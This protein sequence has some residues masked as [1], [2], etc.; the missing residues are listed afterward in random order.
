M[1]QNEIQPQGDLGEGFT[2][3]MSWSEALSLVQISPGSLRLQGPRKARV[4]RMERLRPA[5]W[6]Q[7]TPESSRGK[8][9]V[10]YRDFQGLDKKSIQKNPSIKSP[11]PVGHQLG[12]SKPWL[13][14][15]HHTMPG[16]PEAQDDETSPP[17]QK[18]HQPAARKNVWAACLIAWLHWR[19]VFPN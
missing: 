11:C 19:K 13:W 9:Q 16:H 3:R 10:F 5:L 4:L 7:W 12:R 1:T 18:P 15:C 6:A 8:I 17:P 2:K 14:G